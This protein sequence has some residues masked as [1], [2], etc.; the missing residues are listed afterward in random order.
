METEGNNEE[1]FRKLIREAIPEQPSADFTGL[2]MH[3]VREEAALQ[4]LLQEHILES[5]SPAFNQ[6]ILAQLQ[7]ARPALQYK[8]VIGRKGWYGIAAMVAAIITACAFV[9]ASG[10]SPTLATY[11]NIGLVPGQAFS[12]QLKSIPQLYPLTVIGLAGLLLIDY[13][14]REKLLALNKP[15]RS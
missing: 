12:N 8:P 11:L 15:A 2:V 14:L 3:Q 5:P 1:N 10:N 6:N 9:P 13:F 7:P 4:N